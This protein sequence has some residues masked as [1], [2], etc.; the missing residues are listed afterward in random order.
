MIL[1]HPNIDQYRAALGGTV[2]TLFNRGVLRGTGADRLDLL[3]RLS[4]NATR[5]LA[6]G[7][8]T[9]TILTSDKGRVVEVV[10]VIALEDHVLMVLAGKGTEPVR[11]FLDKYTI[12]DDFAT[13][14]ATADYAVVGLYGDHAKTLAE[15]A[16]G[17]M[18]PDAGAVATAALEEGSVM[19][20]RDA[21]LTGAGG[22]LLVLP[23][24]IFRALEAKLMAAGASRIGEETFNT[25]RVEAG[26]P[27][28]GAE[29]SELYNPLE[30]GLTQ[31][32]SWTKGCYIGQ[33]V[34]AR[35]DTYDKVQR[36]LI[37]VD[38]GAD[39][40]PQ[41]PELEVR[42]EA[43]GKKIGTMTS[44]AYSPALGRMIGLAYVR[45]AYAVPGARVRLAAVGGEVPEESAWKLDGAT[46]TKLPFDR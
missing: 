25:L 8:E 31:Y 43:E 34:I 44:T 1:I 36:H 46:L 33:E 38:F 45:T 16:L 41:G 23:A 17:L 11:A 35:L 21:R 20:L 6:P 28:I 27:A 40:M 10:R 2:Y 15:T 29:L 22:F 37:G 24:A 18:A 9:T 39:V 12:M 7:T 30:A 5:D 26:I 13:A 14:D 42:D 19:M 3:H 4:T 32:I